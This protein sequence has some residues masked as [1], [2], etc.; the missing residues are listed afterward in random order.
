MLYENTAFPCAPALA[1]ARLRTAVVEP[2]S[3]RRGASR[4]A[5]ARPSTM[6]GIHV[7]GMCRPVCA[8]KSPPSMPAASCR[9]TT[10]RTFP[11]LSLSQPPPRLRARLHLWTP[12]PQ[13]RTARRSGHQPVPAARTGAPVAPVLAGAGR[14][15]AGQALPFGAMLK[16]CSAASLPEAHLLCELLDR[17]GIA[18]RVLNQNAQSGLGEIPFTHAWPELWI[19]RERDARHALELVRAWEHAPRSPD[20]GCRG[21]GESN[22]GGFELCW[23]CGASLG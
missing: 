11:S 9:A 1:P 4:P 18:A 19:E 5:G 17:A 21:C 2:P 7:R 12:R 14:S 13:H 6:V 8:P 22:P 10:R 20:I 3:I 16:L 15:R 23:N